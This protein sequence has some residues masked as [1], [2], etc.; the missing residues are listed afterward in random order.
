MQIGKGSSIVKNVSSM[1]CGALVKEPAMITGGEPP[2]QI[3]GFCAQL[4]YKVCVA[5]AWTVV[6]GV[7]LSMIREQALEISRE[8]RP[9]NI[10]GV[11]SARLST[12]ALDTTGGVTVDATELVALPAGVVDGVPEESSGVA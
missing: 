11:A 7:L 10:W 5:C 8:S 9:A 4:L 2:W 1:S 3:V 12:A 6:V